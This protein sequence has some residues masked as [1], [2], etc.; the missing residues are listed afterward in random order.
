MPWFVEKD[1]PAVMA[2]A[3]PFAPM[4]LDYER[5]YALGID[6]W[7]VMQSILKAD[8]PRNIMPLDGVTGRLNLEG[9]QFVR[10][11]TAIEMRDGLPQLL[12]PSPPLQIS[13][14]N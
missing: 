7:R 5:L 13:P 4:P 1:H 12:Q 9:A 3:K 11:L 10:T 8:K 14:T 6:A 2:Y